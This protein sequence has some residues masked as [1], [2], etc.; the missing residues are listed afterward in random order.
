[1][2]S[3]WV[4]RKYDRGEL[5]LW[6]RTRC[7]L[8]AAV[9]CRVRLFCLRRRYR[10]VRAG[11]NHQRPICV[12]A[13][14]PRSREYPVPCTSDQC[15]RD[16]PPFIDNSENPFCLKEPPSRPRVL[17]RVNRMTVSR[18][19]IVGSLNAQSLGN[20]SA[21][22]SQTIV[23]NNFD[24][25]AVVEP[26]HDSADSPSV[27]ASTPPG[28]RVLERARPRTGK[29][30]TSL[31]TNHGGI[32]VF[33][34]SDLQVK[35]I[36]FPAYK[37]FELLTMFVRID[38][39]SFV[40]VVVYRPDPASAVTD[41]FFVDWADILERT[42]AF[43]GCVI[44]GDVNLHLNDVTNT[45]SIRFHTLLD[46]FNLCDHVGQPTRGD[47]QL[48]IFVCRS[49]QPAPVVGLIHRCCPTTL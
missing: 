3:Q 32:C 21:A 49:D 15:T 19:I 27:V 30:A 10:G 48:D 16:F 22:I 6:R 11:R 13:S 24:L 26:W 23:D 17:R 35:L 5:L 36:D 8:P 9:I 42:S 39:M 44:V 37:S 45:S 25:F 41:S 2:N 20:K 31:K 28:Y 14:Q 33:I 1:M 18:S 34:K 12:V 47:N 4:E 43:A 7:L 29:A 46:S 38:T 40:F